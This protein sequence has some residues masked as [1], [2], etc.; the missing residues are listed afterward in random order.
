MRKGFAGRGTLGGGGGGTCRLY[1]GRRIQRIVLLAG[2]CEEA[3]VKRC[4]VLKKCILLIK[5]NKRKLIEM[6]FPETFLYFCML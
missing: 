2:T 3:G 5:N 4:S 1:C 6:Y